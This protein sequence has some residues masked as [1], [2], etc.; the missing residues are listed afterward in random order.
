[1]SWHFFWP[2]QHHVDVICSEGTISCIQYLSTEFVDKRATSPNSLV[3]AVDMQ[4]EFS[5]IQLKWESAAWKVCSS[6]AWWT[7]LALALWP[8]PF[9]SPCLERRYHGGGFGSHAET[10][11]GGHVTEKSTNVAWMHANIMELLFHPWISSSTH[12]LCEKNKSS[13][14]FI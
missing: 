9:P 10:V 4:W 2:V 14:E 11:H 5:S 7:C 6:E 13:F 12:L 3:A 1:M 8:S